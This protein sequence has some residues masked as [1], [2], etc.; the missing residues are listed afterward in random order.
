MHTSLSVQELEDP[1][2]PHRGRN[3]GLGEDMAWSQRTD[4]WPRFGGECSFFK[5]SLR[6]PVADSDFCEALSLP[7]CFCVLFVQF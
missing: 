2:T 5:K 6:D 7:L 1:G 4:E 3:H